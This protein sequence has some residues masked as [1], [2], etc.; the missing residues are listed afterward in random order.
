MKDILD[1]KDMENYRHELKEQNRGKSV[2]PFIL[3]DKI[4]EILARIRAVFNAS[5]ISLE[6]HIVP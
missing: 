1:L 3:L 6:S 4:I 2:R 5:F